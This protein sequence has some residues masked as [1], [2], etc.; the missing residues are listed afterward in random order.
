MITKVSHSVV[1]EQLYIL[2]EAST[3]DKKL[4]YLQPVSVCRARYDTI[5]HT[6]VRRN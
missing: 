4:T 3:W 6:F 5:R 2:V 1:S